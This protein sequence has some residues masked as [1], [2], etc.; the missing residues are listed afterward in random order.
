MGSGGYRYGAGRPASHVK[1]E[2]CLRLDV[3]EL[4]R[5]DMLAGGFYFWRW[6]NS[7]TG[8]E[9]GS[10]GI[11]TGAGRARLNYSHN[12]QSINDDVR[13]V[14]TACNYGGARPWFM[15][16][17]C[18]RRVAVLCLRSGRFMCRHCGRV[19]YAS[20]AD[21]V[22]GRAWRRQ[23]K[24]EARLAEGWRRPKGMHRATRERIVNG[25]FDCERRR[26]EALSAYVHR[27]GLLG[28][29]GF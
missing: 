27:L 22:M 16:P 17:R 5:R 14:E 25:I 12:G 13:I 9:V 23:A 3:R 29:L 6:S 26:D 28:D 7:Y 18:S 4:A 20:Q 24:L 21:D 1:A 10:I 8:E 19:V 11:N 2:H 15:C